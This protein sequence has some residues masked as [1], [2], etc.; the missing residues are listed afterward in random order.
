[1][2]RYIGLD[3]HASSSTVAT[4]GR[5]GRR[6]H[7]QV[8][9]TSAGALIRVLRGIFKGAARTVIGRAKDEPLYGRYLRLGRSERSQR[10]GSR[11]EEEAGL[12]VS[13]A[14]RTLLLPRV[15][16][17]RPTGIHEAWIPALGRHGER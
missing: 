16:G 1:M 4:V 17:A 5:S 7:S 2:D 6:L 12:S 10:V 8:V 14:S 9:E 3:A 11:Q 13:A 15:W